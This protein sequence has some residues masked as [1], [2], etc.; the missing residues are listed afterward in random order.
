[1]LN[2]SQ[3]TPPNF[4]KRTL[5]GLD[6]VQERVVLN[7][8]RDDVVMKIDPETPTNGGT[9]S[10][11]PP[12]ICWTLPSFVMMRAVTPDSSSSEMGE[13]LDKA[14]SKAKQGT[15]EASARVGPNDVHRN[16]SFLALLWTGLTAPPHGL[17]WLASGRRGSRMVPHLTPPTVRELRSSS[18]AY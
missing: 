10:G 12:G 17:T 5:L 4:F 15:R 13:A 8:T 11:K 16:E 7:K 14:I 1:M 6:D 2:E 18:R 9:L 3:T